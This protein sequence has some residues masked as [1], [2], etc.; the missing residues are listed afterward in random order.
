VSLVFCPASCLLI[1]QSLFSSIF[2]P[3]AILLMTHLSPIVSPFLDT[4]SDSLACTAILGIFAPPSSYR[5]GFVILPGHVRDIAASF[6]LLLR[7]SSEIA[8]LHLQCSPL[9]QLPVLLLTVLL[10]CILSF[11][12]CTLSVGFSVQLLGCSSDF[13]A[14]FS[15]NRLNKVPIPY[16][17]ISVFQR[18]KMPKPVAFAVYAVNAYW[19]SPGDVRL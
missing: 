17:E 1:P 13:A 5:R 16:F 11:V 18:Y 15:T 14:L 19:S 8:W 7:N 3:I 9:L 10:H 2:A 12:N 4:I 6:D